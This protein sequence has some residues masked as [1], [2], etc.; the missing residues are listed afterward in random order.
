[1]VARATSSF[2][3]TVSWK[4]GAR[5]ILEQSREFKFSEENIVYHVG[6]PYSYRQEGKVPNIQFSISED[7]LR[8]DI[9]VD[10]RSSK[11]P[12]AMWNGHLDLC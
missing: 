2:A 12:T 10:Y 9:D 8:A 3:F 6:Y 7:G 4:P 1:M 11:L 5:Q